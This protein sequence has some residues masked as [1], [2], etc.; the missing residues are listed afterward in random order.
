MEALLSIVIGALTAVGVY[1]ILRRRS[2][3]MILGLTFLS[4]AVNL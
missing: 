4:Y 1:L 3:P 2:F